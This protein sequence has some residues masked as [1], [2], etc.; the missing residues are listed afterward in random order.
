MSFSIGRVRNDFTEPS[1]KYSYSWA[2]HDRSWISAT[3]LKTAN[4]FHFLAVWVWKLLVPRS[5]TRG[6][7]FQQRQRSRQSRWGATP[8]TPGMPPANCQLHQMFLIPSWISVSSWIHYLQKSLLLQH[9]NIQTQEAQ[10]LQTL[11]MY[12]PQEVPTLEI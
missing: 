9:E 12:K 1:P 7:R 4:L 2:W 3:F 6:G 8:P 11:Q 5:W 10:M